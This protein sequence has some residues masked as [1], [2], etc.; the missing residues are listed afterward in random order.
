M[1]IRPNYNE[2]FSVKYLST[3][4]ENYEKRS[5]SKILPNTAFKG[6]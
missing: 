3:L 1:Q 2:N 5:K 4:K 6:G